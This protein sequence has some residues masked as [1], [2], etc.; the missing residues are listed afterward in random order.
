MDVLRSLFF[1]LT[2]VLL[3][4]VFFFTDV[5][6]CPGL[7]DPAD[8]EG[9]QGR[10][11]S[12]GEDQGVHRG[13]AALHLHVPVPSNEAGRR[14]CCFCFEPWDCYCSRFKRNRAVGLSVLYSNTSH[15]TTCV[16]GRWDCS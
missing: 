12:G 14:D 8:K 11:A 10:T 16:T 15:K 5:R 1:L 13:Q 7:E 3:L 4:P 9:V 6:P 2:D